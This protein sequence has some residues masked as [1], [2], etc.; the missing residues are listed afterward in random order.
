MRKRMKKTTKCFVLMMVLL[1]LLP[2]VLPVYAL[3]DTAQPL[4]EQKKDTTPTVSLEWALNEGDYMQGGVAYPSTSSTHGYDTMRFKVILNGTLP[5]GES[6]TVELE[7]YG[8]SAP[9]NSLTLSK[10]SVTLSN[11]NP[12][13]Y[14][15]VSLNGNLF[16]AHT[17]SIRLDTKDNSTGN[18][19]TP[20]GGIRISQVNGHAQIDTANRNLVCAIPS[21]ASFTVGINKNNSFSYY[22]KGDKLSNY[23]P[24]AYVYSS[25]PTVRSGNFINMPS[26]IEEK[27]WNW[28]DPVSTSIYLDPMEYFKTGEI[29]Y[30][31]DYL[32]DNEI[33][34]YYRI[35]GKISDNHKIANEAVWW[36]LIHGENVVEEGSM[37]NPG[38]SGKSFSEPNEKGIKAEGRAMIA[39]QNRYLEIPESGLPKIVIYNDSDLSNRNFSGFGYDAIA[40]D[41]TAPV[42]ENY[43]IPSGTYSYGDSIYMTI[44]FS[45]P[46]QVLNKNM[47]IEAL[48]KNDVGGSL[49]F[50][51]F[52][53]SYTNALVFKTTLDSNTEINCSNLKIIDFKDTNIA[54]LSWNETNRNN[55]FNVPKAGY[56]DN[57]IATVQCSIDTRV[58]TVSV[59]SSTAGTKKSHTATLEIGK[60][61]AGTKV[62]YIWSESKTPPTNESWSTLTF[63]EPTTQTFTKSNGTGIY[64][65]HLQVIGASQRVVTKTVGPLWL[66]NSPPNIHSVQV[67]NPSSYLSKRKLEFYIST[68]EYEA[69]VDNYYLYYKSRNGGNVTM[70]DITNKVSVSNV[71]SGVKITVEVDAAN[72]YGDASGAS[73][74]IDLPADSFDGYLLGLGAKDKIGNA[75]SDSQIVWY[76]DIVMFDNRDK[77]AMSVTTKTDEAFLDT[78][79]YY[80][81][82]ENGSSRSISMQATGISGNSSD[83]FVLSRIIKDGVTIYNK[84]GN[85]NN[86]YGILSCIT[87]PAQLSATLV[88]DERAVGYYEFIFEYTGGK[89][90]EVVPIL[91]SHREE[92][93]TPENYLSLFEPGRLLNNKVWQISTKYYYS[94]N[95]GARTTYSVEKVPIFSSREKAEEFIRYMEYQDI[96]LLYIGDESDPEMQAIINALNSDGLNM[97]Y[98]KAPGQENISA[99]G[100]QL[101][102]R[103]KSSSWE[104]SGELDASD[105]V[106]YY[107]GNATSE[108]DRVTVNDGI[109]PDFPD[110]LKEAIEKNV[111]KIVG[112]N[113]WIYLTKNKSS[114]TDSNGQPFYDS[115]AIYLAPLTYENANIYNKSIRYLGDSEIYGETVMM[116]I[117]GVSTEVALAKNY[118]T[119]FDGHYGRIYFRLLNSESEYCVITSGENLADKITATGL[120]EFVELGNGFKKYIVYID[121]SAPV[122]EYDYQRS[123][124]SGTAYIDP[125][126]SGSSIRASSIIL[127]RVLSLANYT[128]TLRAELD[129]QAYIYITNAKDNETHFLTMS[130]LDALMA[131]GGLTLGVGIHNI[132]I[133]DRFGNGYSVSLKINSEDAHV[134]F[135]TKNGNQMKIIINRSASEIEPGSFAIYLDG[136]IISDTYISQFTSD[137]SGVYRVVFKDIYGAEVDEQSIFRRSAPDLKFSY[138]NAETSRYD[139]IVPST[140]LST[141][142]KPA[143][144]QI[145]G[146]NSYFL[147]ADTTIRFTW[148]STYELSVISGTPSYTLPDYGDGYAFIDATG[149][150][151]AIKVSYKKD[152]NCFV[153]IS[154]VPDNDAPEVV[155]TATVPDYRYSARYGEKS[156]LIEKVGDIEF[157]LDDGAV[158]PA[159]SL[160]FTWSDVNPIY[161]ITLTYNDGEPIVLDHNLSSYTVTEKGK[162]VITATDVIGNTVTKTLTIADDLKL[163][164]Y[165]DGVETEYKDDPLEYIA[166]GKYLDTQYT[167]N[168][169]RLKVGEQS[170]FAILY[171]DG[172]T[173]FI[174]GFQY[175]KDQ[176][177]LYTL[178]YDDYDSA[179]NLGT[180]AGIEIID[181]IDLDATIKGGVLFDNP[182]ILKFEYDYENETLTAIIPKCTVEKEYWQIRIS[183]INDVKQRVIQIER[184]DTIPEITLEREGGGRIDA[185][186]V[187]FVGVNKAVFV[188]EETIEDS[189]KSIML[190]YSKEFNYGFEGIEPY[191]IYK[192][193]KVAPIT[194]EGYYRLVVYNLYG[195]V[196]ILQFKISYGL[197]ISLDTLY[198]SGI[199]RKFEID[200]PGE[201]SYQTNGNAT[202]T[203]WN[204][205]C[206]VNITKNGEAYEITP[207]LDE[208]KSCLSFSLHEIGEYKVTIRDDCKNEYF[209]NLLI[210]APSQI[211]FNEA[212]LGGFNEAALRKDELY[213]N[214]SV[215]IIYDAIVAGGIK[216]IWMYTDGNIENA[217]LIYDIV[218]DIKTEYSE[219]G[220]KNA[221]GKDGDG[222]YTV[223][224]ADE[225]GNQVSVEI[226]IST[227]QQLSL[228]RLIQNSTIEQS[229]ELA[230]AIS[231]GMWTNRTAIFYNIADEYSFKVDGKA[232]SFKDGKYSL[233]FPRDKAEGEVL[234]L[235]EFVDEYGNSYSIN[236]HLYRKVPEVALN[237]DVQL[238]DL[239]GSM[240]SKEPFGYN[241][242]DDKISA[243]Y[244]KDNGESITYTNGT[245]LLEDGVYVITFVDIAGNQT[246]RTVTVDTVVDYQ[247]QNSDFEVVY[248]GVTVDT[249]LSIKA[250][251]EALTVVKILK[252][253]VPVEGNQRAFSEH[254]SY[255]VTVM[256]P[257]GNTTTV[258]FTIYRHA[259]KSSVYTASPDYAISQIWFYLDGF[260]VSLA[261]DVTVNENGQQQYDFSVDGLYEI[262]LLHIPSG[263]YSSLE[264]TI[265]NLAPTATLTGVE[266]GGTTR[267]DVSFAGLVKGDS[268]VIYRDG[269]LYK[270]ITYQGGTLESLNKAGDYTVIF[271]DEAGNTIEYS[272]TREFVTNAASNIVIILL[273]VLVSTGGLIY[274]GFKGKKKIK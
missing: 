153:I 149:S 127:K 18:I 16:D 103:Y 4:A 263:T 52:S 197:N 41:S 88:V 207:V 220:F 2:T 162:Y 233:E 257:I 122:L 128:G 192:D 267:G 190:Y 163:G 175:T 135:D 177:I 6:V 234:H 188:S 241:W 17:G 160:T 39:S 8:I 260:K 274:L 69:P 216:A 228:G 48:V 43:Q 36:K 202:F 211:S 168:E 22:D 21:N 70:V 58:P 219:E 133:Y 243:S 76:G 40:V 42:I 30:I 120:Y 179:E 256:D 157:I 265:D 262:T 184:S 112:E 142:M 60:I 139:E 134:N 66:D 261:G 230:E 178:N 174:R 173:S 132:Y 104:P 126:L 3:G 67:E 166:D 266:N 148:N 5:D 238:I 71:A 155:M 137:K 57:P 25:F 196:Q 251:S 86:D 108:G 80:N 75:H 247:M 87:D 50:D 106:Y 83:T 102:I 186:S 11:T 182:F 159:T 255:E 44:Y 268:V 105:W 259:L 170:S 29:K 225:Y 154:C 107:Y 176:I 206:T 20:L 32:I 258:S 130:E 180:I 222:T 249:S 10:S 79:I 253:G 189:L 85:L 254:G 208:K 165:I 125:L 185:N 37:D 161:Q 218:S 136:E 62:K 7:R 140:E 51:Y 78:N 93:S 236:V 95:N 231:N 237:A 129:D 73:G 34:Y 90:S 167:G 201:F 164:Y 144:M 213:T 12:Y 91:F 152:P 244:K 97:L 203:I 56:Y 121:N 35:Y 77:F 61:G 9:T 191:E 82:T 193:G 150:N 271:S 110:L 270:N 264:I 172:I 199:S 156:V 209:I 273:L 116:E 138:Y 54:D 53:G 250:P 111:D 64:Y 68:A 215:S 200:E 204:T 28:S 101:W 252:D 227:K 63:N 158:R 23:Y 242:T 187:S 217:T 151:W 239:N 14:L 81:V 143:Y 245:E 223:F 33:N 59:I 96:S 195:N 210:A 24:D 146:S 226:R 31:N 117:G 240:Y 232:V 214:G 246:T 84:N 27:K 183:D 124:T 47:R 19:Y 248:S 235:I 1:L 65:L 205:A 38:G 45:E 221:I 13:Q 74:I 141:T 131:D 55:I 269:K 99:A 194:D 212:Y 114:V 169:V 198:D 272:F 46:V 115:T 89:E 72:V 100:S 49:L 181:K 119:H 15:T 224:F 145:T 92:K 118:I 113:G 229:C 109:N 94:M 171:S 98:N 147:V 123:S 26:H